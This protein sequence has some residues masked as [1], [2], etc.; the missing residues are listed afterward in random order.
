M[1]TILSTVIVILYLTGKT[2]IVHFTLLKVWTHLVHRSS[3]EVIA[4]EVCEWSLRPKILVAYNGWH[5]IKDKL[6]P[7]GVV[8]ASKDY[9]QQYAGYIDVGVWHDGVDSSRQSLSH[10]TE[11]VWSSGRFT[12]GVCVLCHWSRAF[13]ADLLMQVTTLLLCM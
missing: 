6:T 10:V 13:C 9:S 4:E 8:V 5:V 7:K 1:D 12:S 2:F 11:G 3:P